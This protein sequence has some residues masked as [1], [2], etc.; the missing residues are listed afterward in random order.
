MT[1]EQIEKM[2]AACAKAKAAATEIDVLSDEIEDILEQHDARET[3]RI[4]RDEADVS[5]EWMR[6]ITKGSAA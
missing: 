4:I 2:T 3:A 6:R 1:R 5:I